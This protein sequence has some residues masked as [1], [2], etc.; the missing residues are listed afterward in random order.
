MKSAQYSA[1]LD[2]DY[3]QRGPLSVRSL[4]ANEEESAAYCTASEEGAYLFSLLPA[5]DEVS[6]TS[7]FHWNTVSVPFETPHCAL[8]EFYLHP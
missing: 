1:S 4:V 8:S 2:S 3:N 5:V 7:E 6:E